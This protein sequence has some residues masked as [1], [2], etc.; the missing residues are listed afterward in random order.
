MLVLPKDNKMEFGFDLWPQKR[1][2]KK[3]EFTDF[4]KDAGL[5]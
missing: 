4:Q 3:I 1:K 5:Q 2:R